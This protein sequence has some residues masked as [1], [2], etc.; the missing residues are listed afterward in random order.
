MVTDTS[1]G[2]GSIGPDLELNLGFSDTISS[3]GV[4]CVLLSGFHSG[5]LLA[6]LS[7]S[8]LQFIGILLLK[9]IRHISALGHS[10]QLDNL[11]TRNFPEQNL[12][13]C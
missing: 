3:S 11:Q 4:A 13:T 1:S 2:H 5:A 10:G 6:S 7:K 8:S 9:P 12:A